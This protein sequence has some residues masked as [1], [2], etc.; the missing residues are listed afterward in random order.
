M[1][2]RLT[3]WHRLSLWWGKLRCSHPDA[4]IEWDYIMT[5]DG[6]PVALCHDCGKIWLRGPRWR[7]FKRRGKL[8]EDVT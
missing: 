5:Y 6:C 3:L 8:P 7:L 4:E 2:E 1:V